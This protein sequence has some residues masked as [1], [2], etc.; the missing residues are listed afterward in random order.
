MAAKLT[1]P[2][3]Y[4]G[5]TP[6]IELA[7]AKRLKGAGG[8]IHLPSSVGTVAR[9]EGEPS[10]NGARDWVCF[11]SDWLPG[12]TI[13]EIV[14]R[15]PNVV[16]ASLIA[17]VA[18]ELLTAVRFFEARGLKHDDLHLGNL[19]LVSPDPDLVAIDPE[20]RDPHLTVIDIGSTKDIDRSTRKDDDDWSSVARCLATLY[21][22]LHQNRREASRYPEFMRHFRAFIEQISDEDPSR[23]FPDPGDYISRLREA[24]A[25]ITLQ[26]RRGNQF[27]PFSAIS[28]EH[29]ASDELLLKLFVESLPWIELVS[30]GDPCLLFGP[31]G[32]GKSMVFRYLSVR[33]H[34][35]ARN[36]PAAALRKTGFFGV[37][38]GCA[39]D[40]GNDLQWLTRKQGRTA[41]RAQEITT[42]FNL[43]LARELFRSLA[44][45]AQAPAVANELGLSDTVKISIAE[46]VIQQ[47]GSALSMLR[48][49]GMD[50]FQ[51]CVDALDQA[52]LN[53]SRDLIA[54]RPPTSP[55]LPATF[56]RDLSRHIL[57]VAPN[58][59][60]CRITFLLDDY[61]QSR[62]HADIQKI[63]NTIVWQRDSSFT[64]MVSSEPYGFDTTH[65]DGAQID[66]NREFTPIDA[67]SLTLGNDKRAQRRIFITN[68]LNK[69][70]Q[71]AKYEGTAEVL[72]GESTFKEDT[73]LALAIRGEKHQS[74]SGKKTHYHGLHVLSDAWSGDVAT[75]LHI[76]REMFARA[77]VD[78]KTVRPI[79]AEMQHDSITKISS[80]MRARVRDLHPF[81]DQMHRIMAAFGDTAARILVEGKLQDVEGN[82]CPQRRYRME[83]SLSPGSTLDAELLKEANGEHLVALRKELVRRGVFIEHPESRGK[84][85]PGHR[86]VRWELRTSVLPSF[87]T[88][89]I[90]KD[91][92]DVKRIEDFVELLMKPDVYMEKVWLRY[93]GDSALFE[94]TQGVLL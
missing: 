66:A 45:C 5:S 86:T 37:Y 74:R 11:I 59:D 81:G 9:F 27:E 17:R 42:Y 73:D 39:S 88:S 68:L 77:K 92:I 94:H 76:M 46:H 91:Y 62:L 12:Q 67:G 36:A 71:T 85:S 38:I 44:T 50:L 93:G 48:I 25:T 82:A 21:N 31:R 60:H 29:L 15:T 79:T 14:R 18:I 33:T 61:T 40:L 80:G 90:R 84:E 75:I 70:L 1:L 4:D 22:V 8:L 89:L 78:A 72:I 7:N 83:M 20:R 32:C 24:A 10:A 52:R 30:K 64:F 58:F 16:T 3:D 53:L 34:V 41:E 13:E 28:A 57:S 43:V 54:S 69:R 87:G 26:P 51:S 35:S 47:C 23:F 6:L 56:I 55:A 19:M 2:D 65:F 63:L 49:K